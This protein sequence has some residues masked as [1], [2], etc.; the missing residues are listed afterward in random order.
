MSAPRI[1]GGEINTNDFDEDTAIEAMMEEPFLIR[2]PLIEAEGELACG[3]DNPL[4][5]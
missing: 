3:F 4:E 1:K 2:R 5:T